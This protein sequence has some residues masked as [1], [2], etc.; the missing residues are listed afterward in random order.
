LKQINKTQLLGYAVLG[1][2]LFT[3]LGGIQL[4]PGLFPLSFTGMKLSITVKD[5]TNNQP[6]QNAVVTITGIDWQDTGVHVPLN[7][8]LEPTDKDGKTGSSIST[9]GTAY[10][11]IQAEGYETKTSTITAEST[12]TAS[13]TIKLTPKQP[14]TEN[15]IPPPE[16]PEEETPE[17]PEE[18][19]P[20]TEPPNETPIDVTDNI[21]ETIQ[22]Y[23]LFTGLLGIGLITLGQT[24]EEQR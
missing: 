23:S 12:V 13:K 7:V 14:T 11:S 18:T 2:S 4:V 5:S 24:T 3:Y 8:E 17:E 9:W 16:E 20:N 6:I 1:V 15:P 10:L 19:N 22:N 21:S